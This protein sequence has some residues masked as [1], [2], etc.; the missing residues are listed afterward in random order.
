VVVDVG[1]ILTEE[2]TQCRIVGADAPP[3]EVRLAVVAHAIASIIA[4]RI[5]PGGRAAAKA[6]GGRGQLAEGV[7]AIASNWIA[8]GIDER[9]HIAVAIVDIVVARR[10]VRVAA[11]LDADR[12]AHAVVGEDGEHCPV[13]IGLVGEMAEHIHVVD[14]VTGSVA[15]VL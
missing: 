3:V 4:I 5:R 1:R 12:H 11:D 13:L 10:R 6:L 14:A 7:V 8:A 2:T 15:V 9:H